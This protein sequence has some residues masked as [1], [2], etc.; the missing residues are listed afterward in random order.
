M[1]IQ[2]ETGSIKRFRG[3][4]TDIKPGHDAQAIGELQ[5]TPPAGS[6]F[7]ESDTGDRY[8]WTGSWP[9][10]RQEQTIEGFLERLIDVNTQILSELTAIR[11]GHQE[12]DWGDEV[13][14]EW[15]DN[16]G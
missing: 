15:P 12:Y 11:R 2:L 1:A 3:L 8:V 10:I 9:W 4:S 6:I 7:T 13:E 5:Q 16:E 14:P